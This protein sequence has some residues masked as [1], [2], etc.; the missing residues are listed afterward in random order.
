M[1]NCLISVHATGP[2][3]NGQPTD[4][5]QIAAKFVDDL[6]AAGANVTHASVVSGGENDLTNK[7]SRFPLKSAKPEFYQR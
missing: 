5:D 2:H 3:H 7:D 4:I 6:K 1:G